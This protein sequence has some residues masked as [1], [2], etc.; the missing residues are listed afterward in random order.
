MVLRVRQTLSV[1]EAVSDDLILEDVE[2]SGDQYEDEEHSKEKGDDVRSAEE[3]LP[4][5]PHFEP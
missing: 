4:G 3:L 5:T 1:V 2:S